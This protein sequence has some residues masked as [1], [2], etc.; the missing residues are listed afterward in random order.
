[1]TDL[2]ALTLGELLDA[3]AIERKAQPD[4]GYV[5]LTRDHRYYRSAHGAIRSGALKASKVPGIRGYL[6]RDDDWHR[7]IASFRVDPAPGLPAENDEVAE[8]DAIIDAA[9]SRKTG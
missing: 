1:V 7:W 2:R 4:D 6:V 5:E 3:L 9:L 8:A